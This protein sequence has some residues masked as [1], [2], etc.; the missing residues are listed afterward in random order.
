M[1]RDSLISLEGGALLPGYSV[2]LMAPSLC[3]TRKGHGVYEGRVEEAPTPLDVYNHSLRRRG[4]PDEG[5]W[6]VF[7]QLLAVTVCPTDSAS[8]LQ[9]FEGGKVVYDDPKDPR[10]RPG[11]EFVA[12]V[13][14]GN[15]SSLRYL[16]E[17]KTELGD[18]VAVNINHGCGYYC[19]PCGRQGSIPFD[20]RSGV[21]FTGLGSFNTEWVMKQTGRTH[22]PG[23][24]TQGFVVV[25]AEDVYRIPSEIIKNKNHLT[26]FTN[27]DGL[28]CALGTVKDCGIAACVR[29]E[30]RILVF[31]S[32][33]IGTW[34]GVA[35][36]R[37]KP[38][39]ELHLVDINASNLDRS[40]DLLGI[41]PERRHF[42]SRPELG[43]YF[44]FII[45]AAGHGVLTGDGTMGIRG[46]M[47]AMLASGGTF[48]STSHI[49]VPGGI[50]IGDTDWMLK[51][52]KFGNSISPGRNF[53]GPN[54][55]IAI[56]AENLDRF[57]DFVA[58]I[59]EG[60]FYFGLPEIVRTGGGQYKEIVNE[61]ALYSCM[62]GDE[63]LHRL[64][65][66]TQATN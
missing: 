56:L 62:M 58:E 1:G 43:P 11:H 38:G 23:A 37:Y 22:L 45:D 42:N 21:A 35:A 12:C 51:R 66:Q 49:A 57:G 60:L 59:P 39:A 33:R 41:P 3:F 48:W 2:P 34:L 6:G 31:G 63:E 5:R 61:T 24:Y 15:D 9:Q 32:G 29:D 52:Y 36:L 55:S 25:P 4:E 44:D 53:H 18:F 8:V 26:L 28:A 64:L 19:D 17:R 10:A 40:G 14:G 65:A 27:A 54:G 46:M 16:R 50:L 30:P 13:V 47:N 7:L 20:C